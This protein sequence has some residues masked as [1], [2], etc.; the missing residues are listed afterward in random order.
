MEFKRIFLR[1]LGI[2]KLGIIF[3]SLLTLYHIHRH[4]PIYL[5]GSR[6]LN[7]KV[8]VQAPIPRNL[9]VEVE[10]TDIKWDQYKYLQIVSTVHELCSAV[11]VWKQIEIFGSRAG[12]FVFCS[13]H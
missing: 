9:T 12:R 8:A 5:V 10:S 11:M 13:L 7:S 6:G 1:R 4:A 3:L 2:L